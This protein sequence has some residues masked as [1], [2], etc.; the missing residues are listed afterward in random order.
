[1]IKA[2]RS[3]AQER[4][5][6][7]EQVYKNSKLQGLR[8]LGFEHKVELCKWNH[9]AA[10]EFLSKFERGVSSHQSDSVMP[11]PSHLVECNNV[12]FK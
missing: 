4:E 2:F 3:L 12:G 5:E 10:S 1:M 11:L 6:E 7:C 9:S 8:L